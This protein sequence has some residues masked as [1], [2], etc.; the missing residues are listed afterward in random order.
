MQRGTAGEW[1]S[2]EADPAFCCRFASFSWVTHCEILFDRPPQ[3]EMARERVDF[4]AVDEDLHAGDAGRFDV[5][6][7]T[8]GIHS[9]DLVGR[10]AGMIGAQL[11]RSNRCTP[12]PWASGRYRPQPVSPEESPTPAARLR[13]RRSALRR[14]AWPARRCHRRTCTSR[15]TADEPR[16]PLVRHRTGARESSAR[17][18]GPGAARRVTG[19]VAE[20]NHRGPTNRTAPTRPSGQHA[21]EGSRTRQTRAAAC[22][23]SALDG[24]GRRST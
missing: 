9:Q 17:H 12:R 14:C 24:T 23:S 4:F 22:P 19:T 11:R 18:R 15:S 21:A 3:V 6:A 10:A 5:S 13:R 7:L 20:V 2:V 16:C 8:S 1:R